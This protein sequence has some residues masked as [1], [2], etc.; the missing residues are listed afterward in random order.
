[1]LKTFNHVHKLFCVLL[2]ENKEANRFQY[3]PPN[4][5]MHWFLSANLN[6]RMSRK[7]GKRP[8]ARRPSES[9]SPERRLETAVP[10]QQRK[11][12]CCSGNHM[13][14]MR[15]RQQSTSRSKLLSP[16]TFN[17][18]ELKDAFKIGHA[19]WLFIQIRAICVCVLCG[20][21]SFRVNVWWWSTVH[22]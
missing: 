19:L 11:P 6:D 1:M 21:N 8:R 4:K 17:K 10:P 18:T 3:I 22:S 5:P 12:C 14:V 15:A 20:W 16:L 2:R 7:S 13:R 9:E